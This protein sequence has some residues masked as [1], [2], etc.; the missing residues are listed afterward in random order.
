[1]DAARLP[2]NGTTPVSK[3]DGI[4]LSSLDPVPPMH[5]RRDSRLA[6]ADG[7]NCAASERFCRHIETLTELRSKE[8]RN[9]V[10]GED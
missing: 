9:E 1:M 10:Q 4:W 2:V 8:K 7:G 6:G 5:V 3:L